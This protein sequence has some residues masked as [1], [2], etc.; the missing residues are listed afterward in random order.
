MDCRVAWL[1]AVTP[2]VAIQL[3]SGSAEMDWRVA[4]LLAVTIPLEWIT[5]PIRCASV[6]GSETDTQCGGDPAIGVA[7]QALGLVDGLEHGLIPGL[8]AA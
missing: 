5:A 4:W 2:S 7:R 8:D 1:L 3:L 6:L